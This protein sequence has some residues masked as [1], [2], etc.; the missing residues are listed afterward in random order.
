MTF[1]CGPKCFGT[2]FPFSSSDHIDFLDTLD[3]G[4]CP[5]PCK[6]C[7][8]ACIGNELMDCIQCDV[9]DKWLHKDCADLEFD[10]DYYINSS[11]DFICSPRCV[12]KC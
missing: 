7:K 10:F 12:V 4:N 1:T 2:I 6:K 9:C 5:Y 11:Q 8:K 3:N